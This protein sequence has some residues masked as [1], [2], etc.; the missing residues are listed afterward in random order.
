MVKAPEVTVPQVPEVYVY[1]D[2]RDKEIPN[3]FPFPTRYEPQLE[4]E[5]AIGK[6]VAVQSHFLS[7]NFV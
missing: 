6:C 3:P 2:S 5:L 7:T 1:D 4:A